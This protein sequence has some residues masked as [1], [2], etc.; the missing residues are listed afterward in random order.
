VIGIIVLIYS[1]S[2]K[3]QLPASIAIHNQCSKTELI[4]PVYFGN[5]SVF[6]ELSSQQIDVKTTM[7]PYFEVN[8]TQDEFVRVLLYKLQKHSSW[9]HEDISTAMT[10]AEPTCIYMLIVW[11]IKDSMHL[12]HVALL[13]SIR[14]FKWNEENLKKFYDKNSNRLKGYNDSTLIAWAIDNS[15][16][17]ITKFQVKKIP[18]LSISISEERKGG[19]AI[20]PLWIDEE[21]WV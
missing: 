9:P 6:L 13:E 4:S 16:V 3:L 15:T 7:R 5:D 17:L 8:A 14:K 18:E 12:M 2:F 11:K 10:A 21:R 19:Y 20:K 1:V